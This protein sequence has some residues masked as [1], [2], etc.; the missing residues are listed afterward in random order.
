L[1]G[2]GA[3]TST[4]SREGWDHEVVDTAPIIVADLEHAGRALR[5]LAA[6][7]RAPAASS[8]R[9][10]LRD[11]LDLLRRRVLACLAVNHGE[12]PLTRISHQLARGDARAHAL[13]VEWLDVTLVGPERAAMAL[14]EPDL[15]GDA[16][17]RRLARE[18][19]LVE[20]VRADLSLEAVLRDLAV[21]PNGWWRRPWLQAHAMYA[22]WLIGDA[23]VDLA[24]IERPA[25]IVRQTAAALARRSL[26]APEPRWAGLPESSAATD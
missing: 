20:P 14:L 19:P 26:G 10:A 2:L 17:L 18:L 13:A 8:L 22:S 21:D 3:L 15:A 23:P 1:A 11:E 4:A 5:A 7:E 25:P 9:R 16:R 6:A 24:A 12:E